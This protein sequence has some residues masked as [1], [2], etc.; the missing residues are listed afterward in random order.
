MILPLRI[1]QLVRDNSDQKQEAFSVST[2]NEEVGCFPVGDLWAGRVAAGMEAGVFRDH[3][4]RADT[5]EG[6]LEL[7]PL[8][9]SCETG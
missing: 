2:R 5:T 6:A 4:L 1:P 9:T 3:E 7:G 8:L